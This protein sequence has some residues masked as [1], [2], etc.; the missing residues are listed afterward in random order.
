MNHLLRFLLLGKS[1]VLTQE[2]YPQSLVIAGWTGRDTAAVEHHIEELAAI[3][4][5]RPSTV[6][7]FYRVAVPNLTQLVSIQVAGQNT[8]GEIEPVLLSIGPELWLTV[9]SDHTDRQTEAYSVAISKQACAKVLADQAWAYKDVADHLDSIE[10]RSWIDEGGARVLYQEGSLASIRPLPD[11]I[12][13]YSE[14]QANKP[15]AYNDP[16]DKIQPDKIQLKH[17]A[18][19]SDP[20]IAVAL[21]ADSVMYCG[22][23]GAQGGVRAASHFHMEMYDPVLDRRIVHRYRIESLP[24]VA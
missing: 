21:P 17:D 1:Q 2:F 23:L 4:V 24:V 9:G 5:A 22:T 8:S 10:L 11:L 3:G 7:L 14:T 13:R 18:L 6:P 19:A 20:A 16:P 15:Q 12:K